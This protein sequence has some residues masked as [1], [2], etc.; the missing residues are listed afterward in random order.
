M[1]TSVISKISSK[2]EAKTSKTIYITIDL[3]WACDEVL[4]DTISLLDKYR[5][6]ATFFI[7]HKTP[8]LQTIREEKRYDLGIHPNFNPLLLY[9]VSDNKS[10]DTIIDNILEIVP[11]AKTVRSH[12]L[13]Q[14]SKLLDIFK[15]KGLT[16]DCNT[17]ISYQSEIIIKPWV[18]WN[19][20]IRCPHFW[21]DDVDM[22]YQRFDSILTT[23]RSD[24]LK[25]Y[26]FHPIHIYLNT[27]DILYYEKTRGIH[28]L[29][30]KL[31]QN[32][33]KG[34]GTRSK[35]IELLEFIANS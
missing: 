22:I 5:L 18:S 30:S 29:P 12:S 8:I 24:G 4:L 7:T 1:K 23:L 34:Y 3:D 14:S 11:E 31:L 9:N 6:F 25:I 2:F 15:S 32:R 17:Y 16:H 35:F 13:F 28:K 10:A 19:G 27:P 33:Y 20:I 26:D 21:A